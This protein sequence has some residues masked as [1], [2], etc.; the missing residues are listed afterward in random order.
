MY[1]LR[2]SVGGLSPT[3]LL[4]IALA[5]GLLGWLAVAA[6]GFG[7]ALALA[8]CAA[9]VF[10]IVDVSPRGWAIAL[11]LAGHLLAGPLYVRGIVSGSF[12]GLLDLLILVAFGL[13]AFEARSRPRPWRVAVLALAALVM[14]QAFNPMLPSLSYGLTGARP[15][16][17]PLLLLVA[18][19][20]GR[21]NRNDERL[22]IAVG[23][24][25]W[26][27]NVFFAGRQLLV[28]F[29]PTEVAWI[30]STHATYLVGEQIRLLGA[31]RSNQD[32]A[33]LVA[34]AF[35]AVCA[36]ALAR[37]K[38]LSWRLG[39]SLLTLATLAV[40]VGS[41]VRSGLVAGVIGALGVATV[42]ARNRL[43][44]R[45]L[46][47]AGLGLALIVWLV[48]GFGLGLVLPHKEAETVSA[49]VVSVFEPG[50]DYAF[51]QRQTV[52]WPH[53][54][55]EI[56][57]HPL[58][59]GAGSAGP[60]SQT[61]ED[62]PLGSLVPDNGY[63]LMAVQFGLPGLALFVLALALLAVELWRRAS[64]GALAAAAAFGAVVALC[65][66][67]VTG[68][69]VSLVSPSCA[70]AVLVGLGLRAEASGR[71]PVGESRPAVARP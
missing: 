10:A 35:P 57:A 18:V 65:V 7:L 4:P 41:L 22:V 38:R 69:F 14:I 31:T 5:A 64:R 36:C 40:L 62:A 33:F 45:R 6:P 53:V 3:T 46:L 2:R 50:Q 32:F 28:G 68:N 60:L 56:G 54:V 61:R 9:A 20:S 47:G 19:G 70:W 63:L 23:L 39:F 55:H 24:L 51:Q 67:M 12:A 26:A 71:A 49:R 21:L 43:A 58:G 1:A 37:G 48:A 52:V 44:R 42:M 25:G 66:A 15:I 30:Q 59:A 11:A 27:F 8:T 34:I 17:V 13:L 29:T 16:V